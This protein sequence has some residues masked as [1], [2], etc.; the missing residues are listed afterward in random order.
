MAVIQKA[1]ALLK[2]KV[3]GNYSVVLTGRDYTS[4]EELLNGG[5]KGRKEKQ[6]RNKGVKMQ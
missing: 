5:S 6:N 2:D 4:V 1:E 3:P